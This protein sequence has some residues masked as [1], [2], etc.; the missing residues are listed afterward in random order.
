VTV[1]TN[2]KMVVTNV[3]AG[4]VGAST[5]QIVAGLKPGQEVAIPITTQLATSTASGTSGTGTLGAAATGL[6]GGGFG[7]GFTGGGGRAFRG[8]G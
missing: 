1:D 8:G 5:T 6:G 3:I 7:G 2:G 4:L